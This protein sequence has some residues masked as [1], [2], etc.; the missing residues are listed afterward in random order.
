LVLGGNTGEL[1][2]MDMEDYVKVLPAGAWRKGGVRYTHPRYP[3]A[4]ASGIMVHGLASLLEDSIDD[5]H[6]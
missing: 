1:T 6:G 3:P 5:C 4:S 2:I